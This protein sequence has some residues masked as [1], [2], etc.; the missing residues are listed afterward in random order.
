[1][2]RMLS[3]LFVLFVPCLFA[4]PASA[5]T[6]EDVSWKLH[7]IDADNINSS[8]AMVD[9]NR[10]GKLDIIAGQ[11]WYEAPNWKRH[12]VREVE[13]IRGRND[14]YSSLPID[15]NGDGWTDLV[16]VNYRSASLYWVEH[17]GKSLKGPWQKHLI[18]SPGPSETG[19]LADV[20]GDGQL[21]VLPNGT[22]FAA[23]YSFAREKTDEGVKVR[24]QR[25]ELPEQLIGHGLGFGDLNGDGR[26]DIIGAKGWAEAPENARTGR[27]V[28]HELALDRDASIPILVHD[29]DG[30]GKNEIAWGRGHDFGI[31]WLDRDKSTWIRWPIDKSWSQAHAVRMA[32]ID[33]DGRMDLIA[34]KRYFGHDGKD[35]G[36]KMPMVIHW[37]RFDRKSG[38]FVPHL[39]HESEKVAF[40]LDPKV[41][42]IDGDGD[43][44]I[45]CPDRA[46]LYLLENLRVD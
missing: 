19:I 10:D 32:D 11:F 29:F 17:P 40:G 44:D 26:G 25:H 3:R 18:D 22:K 4:I 15:L 6:P 9:V 31:S 41:E 35:P 14:D 28:W 13:V 46:G 1:M 16:S 8:G 7:T 30:D 2:L 38:Q 20:D 36:A 21:D 33:G 34:G 5:D 12:F 23:W 27:W 42:D 43:I 37:Y 45:L 24:W 39:I